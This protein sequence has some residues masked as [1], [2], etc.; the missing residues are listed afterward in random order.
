MSTK[1]IQELSQAI[2]LIKTKI[3]AIHKQ[4]AKIIH[5]RPDVSEPLNFSE[6]KSFADLNKKCEELIDDLKKL[7][8][9]QK[10]LE[11]EFKKVEEGKQVKLTE[12]EFNLLKL[13]Y[14]NK[15]RF[16]RM[17]DIQNLSKIERNRAY[18]RLRVLQI[19]KLVVGNTF[20]AGGMQYSITT[21]GIKR[22]EV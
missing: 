1:S 12:A 17:I 21:E 4:G 19:G 2:I 5:N 8:K 22:I 6:A 9:E 10:R 3:I 13:L 20:K 11:E 18:E 14:D 7:E 16:L 15:H